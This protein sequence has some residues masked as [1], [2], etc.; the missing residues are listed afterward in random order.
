MLTVATKTALRQELKKASQQSLSIGLVPTMG[1]LHQGHLE[2]VEASVRECQFTAA[3]IFV[4]PM[5][6]GADEDLAIYPRTL[7]QDQQL[8]ECAGCNLLFT[9]GASEVYGPELESGTVVRI[10]QLSEAYC[11]KS[12][13]G[14][15]D[16]VAT[17]VTKLFNLV[18]PAK[19]YFGLKDFQQFRIIQ[20]LVEDLDFD[21]ELRGIPT[22]REASGLA[23]SSRNNFL[24]ADQ[25][26]I[27]AGL[28]ATLRSTVEQILAGN[29]EFRQLE[30]GAAQALSQFGIRPDYLA[31]CNA[32][33]L[34]L[35]TASDSKL[36]LLAAGF[37]DSIRLIDNLT[38]EL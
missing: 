3:T 7:E 37:V 32:E 16:G 23:M 22:K 34:A 11:G 14:H 21:L 36:V 10:P 19:A 20:Q 27:A 26:K 29:R 9:P 28:Y 35:A 13:P 1:N 24:T 15:F 17:I 38:V 12:R 33:T 25:R 30:S 2:L 31:I 5:Q 4:N 18:A 8:L 6:F